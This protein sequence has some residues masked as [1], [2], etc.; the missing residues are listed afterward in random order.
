MTAPHHRFTPDE[1]LA[2]ERAA[3]D[4]HEYYD[5]QVYAMSGGTRNHDRIAVS[6][7]RELATQ[8][9]GRRCDVLTSDMRVKVSATGLYTY[10]DASALCSEPEFEDPRNVDVLLNPVL[11]VEVLSESTEG[12]NRGGKFAHY[13][14]IA[15]LQEY[16]LIA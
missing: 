3:R 1:Y 12:Y 15:T 5:G 14:R 13:H 9:R 4:K 16:V 7:T 8:L 10:P 6:A 2:F 11:I